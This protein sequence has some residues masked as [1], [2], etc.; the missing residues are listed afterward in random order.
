MGQKC[1]TRWPY[2]TIQQKGTEHFSDV[3][4]ILKE[5]SVFLRLGDQTK[6]TS[7]A[8]KN[9]QI[10]LEICAKML[11]NSQEAPS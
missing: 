7:A 1:L 10:S 11:R 3:L 5:H 2:T 4:C 9:I 8:V 6:L